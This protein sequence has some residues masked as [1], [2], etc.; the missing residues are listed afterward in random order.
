MKTILC[1]FFATIGAI[2]LAVSLFWSSILGIFGFAAIPFERLQMLQASRQALQATQGK[3]DKMKERH[4]T[5][6]SSISEKRIKKTTMRVSAATIAAGTIGTLAVAG[7]VIT[8]EALDYCAEKKMLYEDDNILN[9][10]E[11]TSFDLDKCHKEVEQDVADIW[12]KLKNSSNETINEVFNTT[13]DYS[14]D[15]WANVK[16][17][18]KE[19]MESSTIVASELL[20]KAMDTYE[21]LEF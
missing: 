15:T 12:V 13:T 4:E 3:V 6:M 21:N 2:L 11:I 5:K 10:T 16:E 18:I 20:D 8:F 19:A 17:N 14:A 7:T 1:T 9:G